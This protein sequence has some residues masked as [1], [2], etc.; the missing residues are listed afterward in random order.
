LNKAIELITQERMA[1][2]PKAEV[3]RK[4]TTRHK[5]LPI[6]YDYCFC[7]QGRTVRRKLPKIFSRQTPRFS[8]LC[9]STN[10]TAGAA[11]TKRKINF[12]KIKINRAGLGD[13]G[14][15]WSK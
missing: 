12:V 7:Q 3:C 9:G 5:F 2:N 14:G 4:F 10:Q 8:G 15:I 6:D 13:A 1:A 11:K